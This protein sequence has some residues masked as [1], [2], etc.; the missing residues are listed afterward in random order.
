MG[1][2]SLVFVR[3][4]IAAG[5][6]FFLVTAGQ[7]QDAP[8][9]EGDS[10]VV[11]VAG[12][13]KDVS[14]ASDSVTIT[15]DTGSIQAAGAS[16][17]ARVNAS[18]DVRLAGA[19][20]RFDG[21]A[22]RDV[23]VAGAS[24][25]IRGRIGGTVSVGAAVATVNAVIGRDLQAG[26]ASLTIGPGS[27]IAGELKAGA[28]TLTIS[29][30]IAGPVTVGGG[31]VTFNA[32][33]DGNVEVR[34]A[35]LVLNPATRIA[36]D[37]TVYS[38][39]EPVIAEGAVVSG[40]ITRITPPDWWHKPTWTWLLGF[41]AYVALG[42]MLAGIVLMLFG[43]RVFNAATEHVRHRPVSSFLFGILALVLVP[44]IAIV[45]TA[46]VIGISTGIAIGFL[47]PFLIVFGH[48]VAAAGIASA[49]LVRRQGP[50][51]TGLAL[52]MLIVG[53]ILL[54]AIGL[55]P[56]VGWAL[57]TVAVILGIGAFTRTIGGRLRREEPGPVVITP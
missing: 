14:T 22:A 53:A 23:Q 38:L 20:V 51:S 21:E 26:A 24:V 27:D 7:A 29:G 32:R 36:G 54:V 40:T 6:T 5:A 9:P 52:L 42:T 35:R 50:L 48:A 13:G 55:I 10:P 33:A 45:L 34:A 37:L 46:T 30:H 8:K 57:V 15:G 47:M 44:F 43:G 49:I 11:D 39:N 16:V 25:D 56:F 28:A 17:T 18:G 3:A 41:A 12:D 2:R 19:Q 31:L 4:A 1:H